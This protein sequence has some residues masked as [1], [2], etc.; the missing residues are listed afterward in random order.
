MNIQNENTELPLMTLQMCLEGEP[1]KTSAGKLP[2]GLSKH[3]ITENYNPYGE[4]HKASGL[5]RSIIVKF[6]SGLNLKGSV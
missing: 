1:A 6:A 4:F 5:F 2:I 3:H